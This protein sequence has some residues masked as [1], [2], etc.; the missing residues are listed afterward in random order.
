MN[1]LFAKQEKFLINDEDK[2]GKTLDSYSDAIEKLILGKTL[3]LSAE[4]YEAGMADPDLEHFTR[5]M[6]K[7]GSSRGVTG[8]PQYFVNG[9]QLA[10]EG[11]PDSEAS[12]ATGRPC[13]TPWC[14]PRRAPWPPRP[15]T[16]TSSPILVW[17]KSSAMQHRSR[18]A[19]QR[20]KRCRRLGTT[21]GSRRG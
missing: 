21:G 18:A 10:G 4:E 11:A 8:A 19:A 9:V 7:Y 3:G 6:W 5:A 13:W 16:R 2:K 1:V 12:L 20:Q 14:T 17:M 15:A